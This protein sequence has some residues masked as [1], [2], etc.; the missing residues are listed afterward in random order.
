ME[1]YTTRLLVK[2]ELDLALNFA[3]PIASQQKYFYF[4]YYNNY[5]ELNEIFTRFFDKKGLYL[6]GIFMN[7]EIVALFPLVFRDD[8]NIGSWDK[9][10]YIND[11]GISYYTAMEL[12]KNFISKNLGFNSKKI[13]CGINSDYSDAV[14][15]F[16][17]EKSEILEETYITNFKFEDVQKFIIPIDHQ[18]LNGSI[19]IYDFKEELKRKEFLEQH[20]EVYRSYFKYH[21]H[22][23]PNYYWTSERLKKHLHDF[24]IIV[25]VWYMSEDNFKILGSIFIREIDGVGDIYG[26]SD[27]LEQDQDFL[28]IEPK[29]TSTKLRE[30]LLIYG[31]ENSQHAD[32]KSMMFFCEDIKDY[33]LAIS[34]GF[35]NMGKYTVY[36]W[37]V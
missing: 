13:Y 34:K 36:L 28:I 35:E 7:C 33:N 9:G 20:N 1:N 24:R 29:L 11:T 21:D 8:D 16:G 17:K 30:L 15:Y 4:P 3:W 14:I 27:Q 18:I 2:N 6:I 37:K 32:T 10:I 22:A 31:I 5:D 26:L 19:R 23:Y 12:F 25:A